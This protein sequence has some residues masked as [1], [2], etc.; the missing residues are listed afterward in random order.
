MTAIGDLGNRPVRRDRPDAE[1]FQRLGA[2]QAA[3]REL[4]G[5]HDRQFGRGN[6]RLRRAAGKQQF[7][8]GAVPCVTDNRRS[9]GEIRAVL[10]ND[11]AR[12]IG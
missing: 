6:Q 10:V 11:H 7:N 8:I 12:L 1:V 9:S 3:R 2:V 4:D 5:T